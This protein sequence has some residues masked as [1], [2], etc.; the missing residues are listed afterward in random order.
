MTLIRGT[1]LSGFPDLVVDL[2]GD[3]LALLRR[4]RLPATAVGD[5]EAFIDYVGVLRVLQ[6]AADATRAPDFGRSL[7][8]RQGI[9]ILGSVGAAARTAPTVA[10]ALATFG[11]YLRAYSPAIQTLIGPAARDRFAV[12][13]FRNLL[14]R[15]PPHSQ[16]IELSLGVALRV[17]RL[18]LGEA[19]SP[20]RVHLPH[21]ALT[22]RREYVGYFGAPP[23]FVDRF[24]G[25]TIRA[26]DLAHPV[27]PDRTT[28]AALTAYLEGASPAVAIGL[29]EAVGELARRLLLTGA[30]DL[31]IL[32]GQLA[33]HPRTVQRRLADQGTT[34]AQVVDEVR[35]RMAETY[36]RDT[37]MSLG[38]LARELGYAEQSA[39]SR[40]SRRW[41]GSSPLAYRRT[42]R[43][44]ASVR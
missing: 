3:P 19:W 6:D 39:L 7:A 18:L 15:L 25:F 12:F 32:A 17:F 14:D 5:Y 10:D 16:G 21:E 34:F 42:L 28:H 9:E 8:A 24:A 2:G 27:S 33:L 23:R 35:R 40:A 37:D 1:S 31:E 26:A 22:A 4:Y 43:R 38:H 44:P 11:R 30:L 36:L 29:S 41:F 13:E 20:V